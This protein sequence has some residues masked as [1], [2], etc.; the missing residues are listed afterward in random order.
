MRDHDAS[1]LTDR[2]A[3]PRPARAGGKP[4]PV[5]ARLTHPH[6]DPGQLT[7]IDAELAERTKTRGR[8]APWACAPAASRLTM[9]G[10]PAISSWSRND[11]RPRAAVTRSRLTIPAVIPRSLAASAESGSNA[12][13]GCWTWPGCSDVTHRG[14]PHRKRR[15]RDTRPSRSRSQARRTAARPD[16]ALPA[17]RLP[18]PA[19]I[20]VPALRH[21][22]RTRGG[23]AHLY[24]WL[25]PRPA[26]GP[27]ASGFGHLRE[28]DR[29]DR[30][31]ARYLVYP[32]LNSVQ[33][34]AVSLTFMA[35]AA[36]ADHAGIWT[37]S[38]FSIL[39]S[40]IA[41]LLSVWAAVRQVIRD[42]RNEPN[43]MVSQRKDVA[44]A[45]I[46]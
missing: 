38:N 25:S 15:T 5:P 11:E 24:E 36:R 28:K 1:H 10:W 6:T 2:R 41:I 46:E 12:A 34:I 18:A 13:G 39:L 33:R 30:Q 22:G 19:R 32:G 4:G 31:D 20:F 27:F 29:R 45:K 44:V 43:I 8:L 23:V 3:E 35:V 14:Q 7:A 42:R 21:A 37:K 26:T 16:S 40:V 9:T 17:M